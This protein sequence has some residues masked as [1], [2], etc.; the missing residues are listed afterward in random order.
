MWVPGS[1]VYVVAILVFFYRWLG[2]EPESRPAVVRP[3][4]PSIGGP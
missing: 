4:T 1:L 3:L 2:P